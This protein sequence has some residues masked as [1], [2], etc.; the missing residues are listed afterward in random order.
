MWTLVFI[1]FVS[2]EPKSVSVGTYSTMYECFDKREALS[3]DSVHHRCE[4][5]TE[6]RAALKMR[7][8]ILA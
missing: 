1:Y 6:V 7:D 4:H 2:G 5:G 8:P 3:V